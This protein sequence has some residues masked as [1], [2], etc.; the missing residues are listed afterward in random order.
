[1]D[2]GSYAVRL[3]EWRRQTADIYR[4]VRAAHAAGPEAAWRRFRER[5]DALYK[6][7]PCSAL[8]EVQR[9]AFGGFA[10]A[11][12]N[13]QF[14]FVGALD[15]AVE[16]ARFD[17]VISEGKLACRRIAVARF[18]HQGRACALDV[19]W[20]E[21]Y[22]GGIWLPV[23]DETNGAA[24]YAGGRYLFDTVKG[25]DLGFDAEKGQIT[26]DF[27][28]LYPPSCA[29]SADW[30]CPLCPPGNRLAFAVEAGEGSFHSKRIITIPAGR[31]S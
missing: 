24:S 29:L 7:H 10:Y 15:Y 2:V 26:L 16:P 20:L 28:F 18:S 5:R 31:E 23:G 19:F 25:A 21:I 11:P 3:A 1:M 17:I 9:G 22:G 14:S 8:T 30:V 12:Y 4:E 13:P 6:H 27:N